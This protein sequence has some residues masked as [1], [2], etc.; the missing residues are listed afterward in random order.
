MKKRYFPLIAISSAMVI[1]GAGAVT[2]EKVISSRIASR[3]YEQLPNATDVEV[4]IPL[5]NLPSDLASD[6]IK[7]AQIDIGQSADDRTKV[8][9][10][11]EI[12]ARNI[13][14]SKPNLIGTLEVTATIPA[15]TILK[16]ADFAD[17]EI[18]GNT[19]QVSV[20]SGG[21]GRASLIPKYSN[22]QL[23]FELKSV[24]IFGSEIPASTLPADVQDQ[25]KSRSVRDL[26][27]PKGMKVKSVSISSKGLSLKLSGS[28]IEIGNF[29]S[30]FKDK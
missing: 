2:A 5:S 12:S 8:S 1:F 26:D 24:S 7:S 23:Y 29:G 19:L 15:A 27:I 18:V 20:G 28:N 21:L 3:I 17:A 10:S 16:Q 22:N 4:T 30:I 14:K 13:E 11:L 25:I 9:P 6:S